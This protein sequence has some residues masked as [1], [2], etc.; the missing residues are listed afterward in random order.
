MAISLPALKAGTDI[1]LPF[2]YES[3]DRSSNRSAYCV[4]ENLYTSHVKPGP[5]CSSFKK[6]GPV[7]MEVEIEQTEISFHLDMLSFHQCL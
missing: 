3:A 7:K 4:S 1:A 2:H 6:M 5:M